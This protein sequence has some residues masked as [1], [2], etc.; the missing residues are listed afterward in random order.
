MAAG[1]EAIGLVNVCVSGSLAATGAAG[2]TVSGKKG[3]WKR[4]WAAPVG[5]QSREPQVKV[6][7]VTDRTRA[8]KPFFTGNCSGSPAIGPPMN[9]A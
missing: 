6:N 2:W 4:G 1:R 8:A 3:E 5:A 9:E 7:K